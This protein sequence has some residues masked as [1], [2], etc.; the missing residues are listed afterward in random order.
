MRLTRRG[1][2]TMVGA[3]AAG[4]WA[5]RGA[6]ALVAPTVVHPRPE[7]Q[8]F[9]SRPD[10]RPPVVGVGRRSARAATGH[11]FLAP[12]SGPG[13][14]GV[15]ILDELGR[16]VW[17][18][19]T[20]PRTAMNFRAGVYRGEP[21]LTW[22]EGKTEHGLGVGEHVIVDSSY[23]ELGRFPAG[24]GLGSDLHEFLL[25]PHGTA[26]VLAYEITSADLSS[27]GHRRGEVVEGIVQELEIPSARVLFEWRSLEHVSVDES[28]VG[29]GPRFDYLHA[30]SV[31][32]DAAGNLLVSARNT[33][34]VYKI[35]RDSGKVI[36]RL[37]GK[38]SDFVLG[39]HAAFAKQ[40][41]A[42]EHAGGRLIT[43]FDNGAATGTGAQ[44]RGIVLALDHARMRATL[45]HQYIH[46]PPCRAHAL[47][48]VQLQ[49][50][51][52][53]LVGWGTAPFFT[54]YTQDGAVAFDATLPDGGENYRALR[55]QWSG[56]PHEPPTLAAR[57]VPTGHLV[58]ASWNGASDVAA[59]R[60]QSGPAADKLS[61]ESR[62]SSQGFETIFHL[63]SAVRQAS[64]TPLDRRGKPLAK[65]A[66][67]QLRG[68]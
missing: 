31:D 29:V 13:Q 2:L 20:S 50:N 33:S 62:V 35:D 27:L 58:A 6:G 45:V 34:A 23:R 44:S 42:R 37:G 56:V 14:R 36:W 60:V 12:S 19:P 1:L 32:V 67:F 28:Y 4:S 5:A 21:V 3:G 25:T 49:T 65:P 47:G 38:K 18:R 52:N 22:W 41:D 48:S 10:L 9:V 17:F 68:H 59:W 54:E 66:A 15:M 26:L 30:N 7:V 53:A 24:G 63:P 40:H 61:E 16:L 46:Q 51:G 55:F 8:R 43:L 57:P 11:L 39:K 64:V